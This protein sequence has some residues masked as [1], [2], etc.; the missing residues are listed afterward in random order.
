MPEVGQLQYQPVDKLRLAAKLLNKAAFQYVIGNRKLTV[1]YFL[2]PSYLEFYL[3]LSV[4]GD[5]ACFCYHF[6]LL[7]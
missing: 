2:Y 6:Y 4:A 1:F 7:L 3:L 5:L